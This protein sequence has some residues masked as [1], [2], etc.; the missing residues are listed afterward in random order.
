MDRICIDNRLA[1]SHPMIFAPRLR[2]YPPPR[3]DAPS[4][5][6]RSPSLLCLAITCHMLIHA[7]CYQISLL[8]VGSVWMI[9]P[10]PSPKIFLDIFAA[11]LQLS[12]VVK[13]TNLTPASLPGLQ[14]LKW[15]SLPGIDRSRKADMAEIKP[16]VGRGTEICAT[17]DV[18]G[19]FFLD[20][21]S[22]KLQF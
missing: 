12:K 21:R 14:R 4:E 7:T 9:L 15:C 1:D 17:V 19:C 18:S 22:L 6:S 8:F 3:A 13:L 16:E 2:F 20:P 11:K 10:K 5:G